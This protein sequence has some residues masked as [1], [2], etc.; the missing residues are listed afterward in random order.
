[1][2]G[3]RI[4]QG[5]RECTIKSQSKSLSTLLLNRQLRGNCTKQTQPALW[6]EKEGRLKVDERMR[7]E[8]A[9]GCTIK[10]KKQI[11]CRSISVRHSRKLCTIKA[12][13]S[14]SQRFAQPGKLPRICTNK[15]Q[16]G[17][18]FSGYGIG[19]R[20]AELLGGHAPVMDLQKTGPTCIRQLS[21]KWDSLRFGRNR[22]AVH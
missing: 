7:I 5:T 21:G 9:R 17:H 20:S 10:A 11:C 16:P 15:T 4:G 3:M 13:R 19:F 8:Q 18:D 12:N 2:K 6:P 14:H 1:M 22:L